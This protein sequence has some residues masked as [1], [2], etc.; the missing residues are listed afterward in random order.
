MDVLGSGWLPEGSGIHSEFVCPTTLS[1]CTVSINI[2]LSF[3]LLYSRRT[4]MV[5]G[6]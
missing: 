3:R 5:H 2:N 1:V 4:G 6:L